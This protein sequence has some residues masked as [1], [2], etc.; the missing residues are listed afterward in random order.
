MTCRFEGAIAGC[1]SYRHR[2]IDLMCMHRILDGIQP[3]RSTDLLVGMWQEAKK[4]LEEKFKSGKNR[5]VA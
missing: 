3:V 4:Q 1:S 5:C 2:L